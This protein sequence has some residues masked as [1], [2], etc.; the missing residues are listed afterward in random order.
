M[1]FKA[2]ISFLL[3][4]VLATGVLSAPAP[5]S[6]SKR[7]SPSI[8]FN[9][10]EG[11][12]SLNGFD[13]F[14]GSSNFIGLNKQTFIQNEIVCSERDIRLVQQQVLVL[15][16]LIKEVLLTQVCEVESQVIVLEQF[17]SGFSL[18]GND[19]ERRNGRFPGYDHSISSHGRDLFGSDG[20]FNVHD[21]G[22]SGL[23]L[24]SNSFFVA[25]D[26]WRDAS[27]PNS[28]QSARDAAR[29][30]AIQLGIQF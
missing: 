20:S 21:L 2:A 24:G 14:Y 19:L 25:G 4:A 18:F 3:T 7:T 6:T 11:H 12:S 29:N 27:S 13:N 23:D 15:Q 28:V 17:Q 10:Y 8:S 30:A 22:F 1:Q 26:N 9:N 16:E 5:H